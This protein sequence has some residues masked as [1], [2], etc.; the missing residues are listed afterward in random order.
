MSTLKN[1]KTSILKKRSV[2]TL[3][4]KIEATQETNEEMRDISE[5]RNESF[6]ESVWPGVTLFCFF[7]WRVI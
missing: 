3:S 5:T 7:T 6:F 2:S 1:D 4:V